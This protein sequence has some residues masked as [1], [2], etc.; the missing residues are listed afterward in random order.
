MRYNIY[1][2]T[3]LLFLFSCDNNNDD[4]DVA[5]SE[6]EK[7]F[8]DLN[9]QISNLNLD[10]SRLDSTINNELR[11]NNFANGSSD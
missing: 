8:M 6:L 1:I 11:T 2:V 3:F 4:N 5:I 10:I 9:N 7:R